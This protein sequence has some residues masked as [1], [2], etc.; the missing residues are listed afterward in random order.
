M[1]Y[2]CFNCEHYI[3]FDHYTYTPEKSTTCPFCHTNL[4]LEIYKKC[5]ICHIYYLS[6]SSHCFKCGY[7]ETKTIT[8]PTPTIKPN[9]LLIEN[10]KQ[11]KLAIK[12]LSKLNTIALDTETNG[13]DPFNNEL[14]L[15]QLGDDKQAYI[16]T[17]IWF[18]LLKKQILWRRT[19]FIMHNAKFDLKFLSYNLG[20]RPP[21][22]FDTMLAERVITC[23]SSRKIALAD[24]S[25][26]YLNIKLQ[27]QDRDQFL[28]LNSKNIKSRL[29]KNLLKYSALDV[30]VLPQIHQYQIEIIKTEK[31]HKT[32]FLENNLVKVINDMELKGIYVDKKRW[33]KIIKELKNDRAQVL[34]KIQKYL[35]NHNF[36]TN[37][38]GEVTY[39]LNSTSQLLEILHRLG[40][41]L[42]S[43][44]DKDLA[45]I[46]HPFVELIRQYRKIEK[47][48]SAF[49]QSFLD[50]VKENSRVYPS[51][52]Q[53]GADTGR[54]SCTKPNLQQIP[55]KE[56]YR[57]CFT[58][59]KGKK[60]ITC[61][62]SQQELRILASLSQDP[63]F[64]DMYKKG[65]DLH[66]AVASMMF[67]IP[68]EK[69][70]KDHHRKIAKTINFGL[71]YGRGPKSL[72]ITLGI[73]EEE[74][75]QLITQ[76][77]KQFSYIKDW[78][79][80]VANEAISNG[81]SLTLLGRKRYYQLPKNSDP[82]F[83]KKASAIGRRGKNTPIQGTASDMIKLALVMIDKSLKKAKLNA[84][85]V[86]TVHDEI[87]V[88]SSIED[89]KKT[90]QIVEDCMVK[91]GQ[92]LV[93]DVPIKAEACI[94]DYW[95]H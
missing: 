79:E 95:T 42:E 20:I 75:H 34:K 85:I 58:A 78:L 90:A 41:K 51:F 77:F 17:P 59:P 57:S 40:I 80:N 67:K 31:L 83:N 53:I 86:N 81:Y 38:L 39:N 62:Y 56:E 84:C 11:F 65:V 48:I 30:Q 7:Q 47:Q 32:I 87:V 74:A 14:L 2:K 29:T 3:S 72:A 1:D 70:T 45:L 50:L 26:K 36:R 5:P 93:A 63:K 69:V 21:R 33:Q 15:I 64:I 55:A 13:L 22:V 46:A 71:V 24:I 60:I 4:H 44:Q 10:L 68:I 28:N 88:E 23:G 49:G 18:H 91:A 89:A 61:D 16:F 66:S 25:T 52:Q 37:M 35:K 9:F 76:Y 6:S 19:T 8:K 92:Q 94:E 73:S 82:D 12:T 43:T 27:K 54:F